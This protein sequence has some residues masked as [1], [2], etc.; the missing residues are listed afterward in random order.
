MR[1]VCW[2]LTSYISIDPVVELVTMAKGVGKG[3]QEM[4]SG[5]R[6][7]TGCHGFLILFAIELVHLI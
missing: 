7:S 5:Y 2:Y 6:W 3:I 1:H 4:A